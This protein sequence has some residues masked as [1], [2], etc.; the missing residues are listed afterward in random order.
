MED[1]VAII[2]MRDAVAELR[3][4]LT[5]VEQMLEEDSDNADAQEVSFETTPVT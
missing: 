5:V 1:N 3:E 2:E 4:Q